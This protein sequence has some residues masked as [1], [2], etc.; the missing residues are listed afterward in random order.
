MYGLP[1]STA[2]EKQ[3]PKK[4]IYDKFALTPKQREAFDADVAK[5]SISAVLSPQSIPALQ[6]SEEV[7]SIYVL[8]IQLKKQNYDPKN[9]LLLTKLIPQHMVLVLRHD[10]QAQVVAFHTRLINSIWQPAEQIQVPIQGLS[11][12]IVWENIIKWAGAI[13]VKED[14]TLVEQIANN[15][16]KKYLETQISIY[17]GLVSREKQQRK[18]FEYFKHLREL[19]EE[20]KSLQ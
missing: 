4:Q 9:I 10:E 2:I 8:T 13:E 16:R 18:A 5:L 7:Q 3:L 17:D 14:K 12:N 6:A 20:L 19:Q 15:A 1:T 11:M